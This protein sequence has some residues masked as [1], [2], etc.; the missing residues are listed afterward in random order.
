VTLLAWAVLLVAS[1]AAPAAAHAQEAAPFC[2]PGQ[3]PT[4][5]LGFGALQQALGSRMGEPTECEHA[6]SDNGDT[7]QHTTTGLAFY[8]K[9]TNT[10]TFTDGWNHWALTPNGPVV[11]SGDQVDPPGAQAG[12]GGDQVAC[13]DVG[14]G[15]CVLTEPGLVETLSLLGQTPTGG[16]LVREIAG[17]GFSVQFAETPPNVLGMFRPNRRDVALSTR[18]TDYPIVDRA[19]VLGHELQ[20]VSDWLSQ[21]P[22]LATASG[23]LATEANAFHTQSQIWLELQGG[24]L[25][26]PANDV[27]REFNAIVRALATAPDTFLSDLVSAYDEEC[28]GG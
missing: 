10:P 6:N 15:P 8:R 27:E 4:F 24:R 2:E 12:R 3:V 11:W 7:L 1:L 16:P 26:P 19:P 25:R 5:A 17:A 13:R 21:G 14:V 23:C 20:H 18:L 28:L 9:S 22:R